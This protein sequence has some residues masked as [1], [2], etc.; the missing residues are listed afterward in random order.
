MSKASPLGGDY[1]SLAEQINKF[2]EDKDQK[3][4]QEANLVV[5]HSYF[6]G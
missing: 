4:L 6:D 1:G 5:R 3:D 2:I